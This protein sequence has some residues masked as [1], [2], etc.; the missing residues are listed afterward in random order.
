M[1]LPSISDMSTAMDVYVITGANRGIGLEFVTQVVNNASNSNAQPPIILAGV[2]DPS[3]AKDLKALKEKNKHLHI[4]ELDVGSEASVRFFAA[5]ASKILTR[6]STTSSSSTSS[7]ATFSP[8]STP[9]TASHDADSSSKTTESS[10]GSGSGLKI[11]HLIN[12]AGIN[13][14]NDNS[15][16]IKASD[17]HETMDINVIGP[18]LL[19]QT[20]FKAGVLAQDVVVVNMS[21]GFGSMG[22]TAA[23]GNVVCLSYSLSKAA[24]CMLSVHQ[25]V[26]LR[27]NGLSGARVIATDPGWVRT[28][29]GGPDGEID[30]DESV[31]GMLGVIR[32]LGKEDTARSYRYDGTKV[33]W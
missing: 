15:L 7:S 16:N 32:G 26:D 31:R 30:A 17:L 24:L 6:I 28:R 27:A 5:Y 12:N 10:S 20:L 18:A 13:K 23:G 2:R 22:V 19:T 11:T 3:D 14:L 9:L 21:S 4:L 33:D 29:M 1:I 8:P 25:S